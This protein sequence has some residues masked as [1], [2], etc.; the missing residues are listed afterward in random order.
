M[1]SASNHFC[2]TK[3]ICLVT[4]N[5]SVL[6]T[7]PMMQRSPAMIT[8]LATHTSRKK[9]SLFNL[10]CS[11]Q[12]VLQVLNNFKYFKIDIKI[13]RLS[14]NSTAMVSWTQELATILQS[15]ALPKDS[16]PLEWT[17]F[18]HCSQCGGPHLP[19]QSGVFPSLCL[20]G[21]QS[22]ILPPTMGCQTLV[23]LA[24][25]ITATFFVCS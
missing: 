6:P 4:P 5:Q 23:P 25:H 22:T 2:L 15:G 21:W 8:S 7:L 13:T 18:R 19:Q 11:V 17:S 14:R 20:G 9:Q 1:P 3:R 24:D 16:L 12:C 10:F